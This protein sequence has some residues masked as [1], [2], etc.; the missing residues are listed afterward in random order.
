MAGDVTA[1]K[2][3][4]GA[5]W[6]P[7]IDPNRWER[8]VERLIDDFFD[9]KARAWWPQRW[10]LPA[11]LN[12][13]PPLLDCY[14]E[15]GEFVVKAELAGVPKHNIE[16]SVTDHT[17]TIKGEKQ[18]E[19]RIETENYYRSERSF[20]S[21]SRS[22]ELPEDVEANKVKASCSNGVIEIRL[23]IAA[24]AKSQTVKV[25]LEEESIDSVGQN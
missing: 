22:L 17:L 25:E 10:P 24:A 18:R 5:P 1:K 19:E 15:K 11:V 3:E 13:E 6:R 8:D 2:P 21:F 14:K 12:L 4:G 16:V 7:F 23:P 20:G 9:R